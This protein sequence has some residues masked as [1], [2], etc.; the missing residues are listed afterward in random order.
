MHRTQ[1]QLYPQQLNWLKH[2]AVEKGIS[3]AQV[4]RNSID[5]YRARIEKAHQRNHQKQNAL[6]AV[7][8][9]SS[10]TQS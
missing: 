5:D 8:S 10:K 9:F 6:T 3:M 1:I 4:I 2:H 7:G